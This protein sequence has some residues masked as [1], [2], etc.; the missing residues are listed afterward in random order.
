[1]QRADKRRREAAT[2]QRSCRPSCRARQSCQLLA[3]TVTTPGR[4]RKRSLIANGLL[5]QRL[6]ANGVRRAR[7]KTKNQRAISD[8]FRTPGYGAGQTQY[9]PRVHG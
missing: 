2:R 1:M 6:S 5:L 3:I 7:T 9:R 8:P 4:V